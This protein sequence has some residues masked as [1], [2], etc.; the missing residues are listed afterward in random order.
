MTHTWTAPRDVIMRA[1]VMWERGRPLATVASGEACEPVRVPVRGPA[2][3]E[4]GAR[5]DELR[6]W[7]DSWRSA[8]AALRVEWK[9]V[10]DRVLGRLQ[11]PV[12]AYLDTIDDIALLARKTK[13]LTWFRQ[14][15]ADTPMPFRAY[16]ARR[17]HRILAIGPDWPAV[18]AAAAWLADNPDSGLHARQIPVAGVHTKIVERYRRDIAEL[19]PASGQK[20]EGSARD[21]FATR[22]G[23]AS[24][25]L[26]LRMRIL[27]DA[28]PGRSP[29]CDIEVPV[30]EAARHPIHADRILVVENEIPFLAL[31]PI[32]GTLAILGNGNAAPSLLAGV[33]WLAQTPILYW[34]DI[35]TWGLV[36]L[37]RVRAAVAGHGSVTS[38]LM[39]HDTLL[40]HRDLWVAEDEPIAEPVPRLT[41]TERALYLNLLE[42]RLGHRVRLEQERVPM[43]TLQSALTATPLDP[44]S[45]GS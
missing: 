24:K 41:E 43:Q 35:D 10:N 28:L 25:P 16:M 12:A 21:W 22:Y 27:D 29:Y 15:V 42:N 18:I 6:A 4:R 2:T 33:E 45:R 17:P 40:A 8:P 34:G 38:V 13:D 37:N 31:P 23:L 9:T 32:P 30:D 20:P 1:A 44:P 19:T 3:V 7:L 36:I 5:Y 26:R 14:A 39:D 11:I